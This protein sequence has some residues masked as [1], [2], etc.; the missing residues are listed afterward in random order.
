MIMLKAHVHLCDNYTSLGAALKMHLQA[1][2]GRCRAMLQ[3][4]LCFR[5]KPGHT[6]EAAVTDIWKASAEVA[7]H[8]PEQV[9]HSSLEARAECTAVD[10]FQ[11]LLR[12]NSGR[13][14]AAH[15]VG[16]SECQLHSQC[17]N[18]SINRLLLLYL[19]FMIVSCLLKQKL[20]EVSRQA[21][22]ERL[23]II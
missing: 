13:V 3:H 19:L 10:G 23:N 18:S 20:Q 9:S 15:G 8:A 6:K 2:L 12:T 4:H 21:E 7:E 16:Y 1:E 22:M 11:S 17:F 14:Y 5:I